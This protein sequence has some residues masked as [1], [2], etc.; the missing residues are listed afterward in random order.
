MDS[1]AGG[2]LVLFLLNMSSPLARTEEEDISKAW[3]GIDKINL[4]QS[5]ERFPVDSLPASKIFFFG[6]RSHVFSRLASLTI[7]NG[8]D[9]DKLLAGL[10]CHRLMQLL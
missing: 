3:P 10:S 8:D 6:S 7:R 9:M 1:R 5:K 2:E 4:C